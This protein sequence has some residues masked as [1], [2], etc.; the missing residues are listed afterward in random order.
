M[1]HQLILQTEMNENKVSWL[2]QKHS[3]TPL[4]ALSRTEKTL[5][6]FATKTRALNYNNAN[7]KQVQQDTLR[8]HTH[9]ISNKFK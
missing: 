8:A 2:V 7:R 9:T 4:Y 1:C 5:I 3:S 6:I